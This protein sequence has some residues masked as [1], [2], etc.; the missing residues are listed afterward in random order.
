[1]YS[2]SIYNIGKIYFKNVDTTASYIRDTTN[3]W[4][5]QVDQKTIAVFV[6]QLFFSFSFCFF[7]DQT[8]VVL[9]LQWSVAS[10]QT[11]IMLAFPLCFRA[12]VAWEQKVPVDTTVEERHDI[13]LAQYRKKRKQKLILCQILSS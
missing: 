11:K 5:C 3:H 2:S 4:L 13:T 7:L 12:M 9:Y 6:D 10:K 8:N 1:M